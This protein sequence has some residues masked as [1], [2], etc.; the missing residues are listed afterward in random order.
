MESRLRSYVLS[1]ALMLPV[2][3]G[4]A[5]QDAVSNGAQAQDGRASAPESVLDPRIERR[6]I[7]EADIDA[8]NFEI[9]VY[10]GMLSIEDFG[11]EPLLGVRLDY[12]L[13]DSVFFEAAISYAEAGETSFETLN[14]GVDLLSDDEREFLQY[15]VAL[16]YNLLPGE[17]FLNKNRAYNNSL[18]LLGGAG[19]TEFAGDEHFTLTLGAGYRL[20]LNDL[21]A[22][23][24]D[25]KDHIFNLDV[26]GKEKTTQNLELSAG[27][28]VFF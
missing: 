26:L 17:A 28:S 12:H 24:V 16:G 13:S 18:F 25:M 4:H 9:G 23:R 3:A 21:V 6:R 14:P 5:A 15:Q 22:I 27:V 2:I 10:A 20:L 7:Q 8:E 11:T 1:V 19:M